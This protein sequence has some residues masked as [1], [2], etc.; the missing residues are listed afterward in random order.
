MPSTKREG[1]SRAVIEAMSCQTVPIVTDVGGLPELVINGESGFIVP[2]K[3]SAAIAKV[4]MELFKNPEKK[5]KVGENAKLRIQTCF[6]LETTVEKTRKLFE[7][8]LKK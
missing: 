6:N 7:D 8:L 4:I 1:L 3:D 2:A 5:K